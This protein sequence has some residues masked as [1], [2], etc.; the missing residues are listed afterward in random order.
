LPPAN[1]ATFQGL[2][3]INH[4]AAFDLDISYRKECV[5]LTGFEIACLRPLIEGCQSCDK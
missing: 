4:V 3:T 2:A 5:E 1:S